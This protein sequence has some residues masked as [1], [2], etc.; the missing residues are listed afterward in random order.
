MEMAAKNVK[1]FCATVTSNSASINIQK[2][3]IRSHKPTQGRGKAQ[4]SKDHPP[5]RCNGPHSPKDCTFK[6]AECY[7]CHKK[8]HIA[9]A[10]K[11]K[12]RHKGKD[13]RKPRSGE[14]HEIEDDTEQVPDEMTLY[15][16]Y[17]A[18][19]VNHFE[20]KVMINDCPLNMRIDTAAD[21]SIMSKDTY[22]QNFSNLP[23]KESTLQL[24]TYSSEIL[25]TC[26]QI[27]CKV[28][29]NGKTFT[30]PCVAARYNKPTLMGKDWLSKLKLD[31]SSVFHIERTKLGQVLKEYSSLF[32]DSYEG[33]KGTV[34]HIRNKED[35][36][37]KYCKARPVPYS[38]KSQVETELKRLEKNGVIVK[39]NYS[40]WATPIVIVPKTDGTV[41][42]CGDYK[43]TIN[44]AVD[45]EKY[46]LPTSQD[47]Y[48]QLSGTS[49]FKVRLVSCILSTQHRSR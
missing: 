40:D 18:D 47:L 46:P 27:E 14:V 11:S 42:L 43:I 45:D 28:V 9:A 1:E 12:P 2:S 4:G 25:D 49:V 37:P 8:G 32:E 22:E 44:Q 48:A 34:A 26:G 3:Y 23:L 20:T 39:T 33:I 19:S 30:L 10:C 29:Y 21:C 13:G 7:N 24:K 35:A 15:C 41:R 5:Y 31:W 17:S 38:Q 6:N 36:K 16:I